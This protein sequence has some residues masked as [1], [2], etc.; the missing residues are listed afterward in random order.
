MEELLQEYGYKEG[1][2]LNE[3]RKKNWTVRVG[4]SKLEAFDKPRINTPGMY[5][6]VDL[7]DLDLKL[8]LDEI[9]KYIK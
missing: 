1:L 6:C 5:Y 3:W 7:K 9:E 8:L 2:F 4:L